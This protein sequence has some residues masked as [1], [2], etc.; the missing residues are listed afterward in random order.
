MKYR[1]KKASADALALYGLGEHADTPQKTQKKKDP[2]FIIG[3]IVCLSLLVLSIAYFVS[4]GLSYSHADDVYS[5]I[6][7]RF[8]VI[9]R[10]PFMAKPKDEPYLLDYDAMLSGGSSF[11]S[12]SQGESI[13]FIRIKSTLRALRR[14]NE[15]VVGWIKIDDTGIDY[16]VVRTTNND[17]Y[18]NHAYDRSYLNAGAIFFDF[19]CTDSLENTYNTV[20]YGHNMFSGIMFH[21]VIKYKDEE[22][23]NSH[24]ITISTD[25][26]IFTFRPFSIYETV[27]TDKYFKVNF[28]SD[29]EFG[30]FAVDVQSRSLFA[31]DIELNGSDRIITFS[32]CTN[33]SEEG[34]L[35]LHAV[36]IEKRN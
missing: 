14:T 10:L 23:F 16:P 13:E 11:V 19:R 24:D 35:V 5:D 21:D 31:T 36:L 1:F 29:E 28:E 6:E 4:A 12:G 2:V 34:R 22:F 25:D 17:F 30:A 7:D 27:S 9:D 8:S 20:I 26:G 32:T 3:I 18:L 15:E 33:D